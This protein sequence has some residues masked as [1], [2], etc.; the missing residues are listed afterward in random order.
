MIGIH[1][2]L[3]KVVTKAWPHK[4]VVARVVAGDWHLSRSPRQAQ[5]V[6]W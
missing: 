4:R 3:A 5:I 6:L 1:L 2:Y